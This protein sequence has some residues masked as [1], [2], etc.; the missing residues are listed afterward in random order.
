MLK[1]EDLK[2]SSR[3]I[4]ILSGLVILLLFFI[5]FHLMFPHFF[6]LKSAPEVV[7]T[8][9]VKDKITEIE[10]DEDRI[11][12]GIHIKTGFVEGEGLMVVVNNCTSCHS[13]KIILQNRMNTDGWNA[14]IKWMQET[15]NL[16]G[17]GVNQEIIVNYLVTN[18]PVKNKGRRENLSGIDWYEL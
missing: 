14:T 12:N 10:V 15:Q 7:L 13:S 1:E 6:E 3:L 11:E 4:R 16:W 8:A 17:L 18:Y 9:L 2:K 5:P